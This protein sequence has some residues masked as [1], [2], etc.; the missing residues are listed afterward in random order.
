[1]NNIDRKTSVASTLTLFRDA[2]VPTARD[3]DSG[4]SAD[5]IRCVNKSGPSTLRSSKRNLDT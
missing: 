4:R 5:E 1:M 2:D 3:Y